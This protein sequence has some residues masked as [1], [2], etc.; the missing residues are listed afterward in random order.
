MK[1]NETEK[2]HFKHV[3]KAALI[4]AIRTVAQTFLASVGT[5]TVLQDVNWAYIASASALAGLCSIAS[6]ILLGLP[7]VPECCH[8]DILDGDKK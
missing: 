2:E 6:S 1:S 8:N 3:M 4:R 7:E 5:A